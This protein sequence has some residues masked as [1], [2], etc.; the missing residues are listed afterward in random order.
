M[1]QT[2]ARSGG[3]RASAVRVAGIVAAAIVAVLWLP[4]GARAKVPIQSRPITVV[5]SAGLPPEVEVDASNAN[6]SVASFHHRVFMVFRT[7]KWQIADDNA[8]M[9]VV[10][11]RDQV[12][13]RHEGTFA[14]NRDIR[15]P[16]LLVFHHRLLLY[17]AL[18]GSNAAAFEPG[19]TVVTRWRG[20]GRW[21]K[22]RH[23]LDPDFIPW[24]LAV[25]RGRAYML[26]Y[27]GGGGTF[28]PNPPPKYVYWLR[29]KDGLRWRGVN[30]KQPIVYTG[31]C[32]ETSFAFRHNGSIVTACQTEEV[33]DLG[34]G[35]KVCTA[36]ADATWRWTCRGDTR[37]LD[38]PMVFADRGHVY[39]IARRQVAF[40]G[41]YD[42]LHK[43]LPDTDAQFAM[44]DAE[45]AA[46]TKRCALW[47]ID[48][49]T[50]E[51]APIVDVP[52]A[53]DTCYPSRIPLGRHRY[54]IYNYT[55][56]L[57][58]SDPPWGTALTTGETLIYRQ[59]LRFP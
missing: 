50:R 33:D 18:L 28:Q 57:D 58:G 27:T 46:T 9:Y 34:W 49:K 42:Y 1:F 20:S 44:Y 47:R 37:R 7:A 38:S 48:P 21:T 6:L 41:E 40:D 13:W 29:S 59:R 54:L 12:H 10:S 15:E 4:A 25:H 22:P 45:Y 26:G 8:R 16:R 55:S 31:Q 36:P 32:G 14:Y 51:F 23:I 43:N 53:G 11:S 30:P 24:D 2:V 17:M 19:G 35:A 3:P 39:V 56:P 52:G 5:P